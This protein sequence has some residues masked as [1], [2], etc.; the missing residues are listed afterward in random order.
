LLQSHK[1]SFLEQSMTDMT[2]GREAATESGL[3]SVAQLL[4]DIFSATA[5]G[6]VLA[7]FSAKR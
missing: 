1:F 7:A 4:K 6:L 3:A 5:L 2:L